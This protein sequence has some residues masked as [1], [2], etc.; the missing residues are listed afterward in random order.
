MS[1]LNMIDRVYLHGGV[2]SIIVG[3]YFC[4]TTGCKLNKSE[5]FFKDNN[6][7]SYALRNH[8]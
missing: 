6:I 3:S 1:L 7:I 5:L 8:K 4:N 2:Y